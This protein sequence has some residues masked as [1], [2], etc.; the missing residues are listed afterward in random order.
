MM[1]PQATFVRWMEKK[2]RIPTG[3]DRVTV[4]LT[5]SLVIVGLT[6]TKTRR[7]TVKRQLTTFS[8]LTYNDS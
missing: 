8:R 7:V 1:I 2:P 6:V 5:V 3:S 4:N